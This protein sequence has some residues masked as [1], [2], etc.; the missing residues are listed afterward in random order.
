MARELGPRLSGDKVRF[1]VRRS[2]EPMTLDVTLGP[3][4]PRDQRE[5]DFGRIPEP[6]PR[7]VDG[8]L[9]LDLGP[10]DVFGAIRGQLLG[11]RTSPVTEDV[12]QR[13]ALRELAGAVVVSRVVGSPAERAGIPLDA[14]I[15][16]VDGQ[17]VRSPSDLAR[18]IVASGHGREVEIAYLARGE[19]HVAKVRLAELAAANDTVPGRPENGIRPQ[20]AP[21]VPDDAPSQRV[22]L[23]ERRVRELE[24]RV[25]DL[26]RLLR[27][28]G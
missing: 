19:R 20:A 17:P 26:E 15:V 18:L 21:L 11:V 14:V 27:Q 5:F 9:P 3:R 24:Q 10:R 22:E 23:L 6:L 28:P 7:P 12:R 8:D 16:A 13:L 25:Q 4:P 1:E 2:G